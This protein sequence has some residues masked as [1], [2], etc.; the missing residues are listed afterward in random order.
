[1]AN[2]GQFI[3]FEGG[4]G[5]GKSTQLRLTA[6]WLQSEGIDLVVTREP[7]DTPLG[8][9][10]RRLLLSGEHTPV[11][12]CELLLFLADRVQHVR[13]V[14]EPELAAGRW[15]ICDRYSDSTLAYQLAGRQLQQDDATLRQ[16]LRF[17]EAGLSPNLTL[18]LDVEPSKG[19]QRVHARAI[20]GE[21]EMTRL[22]EEVLSFHE[23]VHGAFAAICAAESARIVA[24]DG[25]GGVDE[26]Q[27]CIR[28]TI[29]QRGLLP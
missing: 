3:T 28:N 7:G 13:E 23:A 26:V 14:I 24:I 10:I 11:P 21:E 18:W 4:D 20:A 22:D 15:V 1:M 19:L 8:A 6:E 16:M 12:E 17:A 29:R 9:E 2:R 5:S 25:L 27:Q